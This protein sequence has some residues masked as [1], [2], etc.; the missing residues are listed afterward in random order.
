MKTRHAFAL[1]YTILSYPALAQEQ[2]FMGVCDAS[3][4]V[5]L[6]ES[7]FVVADDETSALRIYALSEPDHPVLTDIAQF[8]EPMHEGDEPD[9]EG[10]AKIDDRIYWIASHGL[11]SDALPQETRRRLFAT[12]VEDG[13]TVKPVFSPYKDFLAELVADSKFANFDFQSASE[14]APEAEGGLNIEALA[15]S[16]DGHLMIG[17]RNPQPEGRAIVIPLQN[18]ADVIEKSAKPVFGDASLLDLEGRGIRSMDFVDNRYLIVAGP[19]DKGGGT[20]PRFALFSWSG[21]TAESADGSVTKLSFTF[22]EDVTPEALF[23][24][25]GTGKLIALSDDGDV[26]ID[27]KRCKKK[28]V[29]E[30]KKFFRSFAVDPA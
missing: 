18:P 15:A 6:D 7:N 19:F 2:K 28:S 3:A 8:L 26:F 21:P 27:G 29:P 13:P 17:F 23:S 16:P 11:D 12:D 25:P 14:E 1:A 24:I 9:I 20:S 22:P 4:A 5:A 10:A 30:E